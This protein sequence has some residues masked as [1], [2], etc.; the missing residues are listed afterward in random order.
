[1]S[2]LV[3][4]LTS[5]TKISNVKFTSSQANTNKSQ[6]RKYLNI[7]HQD[8]LSLKIAKDNLH[9]SIR[10]TFFQ[11]LPVRIFTYGEKKSIEDLEVNWR[12]VSSTI[13]SQAPANHHWTPEQQNQAQQKPQLYQDETETIT[14]KMET[15]QSMTPDLCDQNGKWDAQKEDKLCDCEAGQSLPAD[16]NSPV[17]RGWVLPSAAPLHAPLTSARQKKSPLPSLP[18]LPYQLELQISCM[19]DFSPELCSLRERSSSISIMPTICP[20]NIQK[21]CS[22]IANYSN[23][24]WLWCD[25]RALQNEKKTTEYWRK[26]KAPFLDQG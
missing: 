21:S 16:P 13:P 1:M 12:D 26:S 23:L 20:L 25:S 6:S 24:L 19:P 9:V 17:G 22:I 7:Y 11:E 10:A 5:T 3:L 18:P 15:E 2:G 8:M 4:S 14:A